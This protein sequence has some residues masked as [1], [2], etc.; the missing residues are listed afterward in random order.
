MQRELMDFLVELGARLARL[1]PGTTVAIED[2]HRT[3][4]SFA[5][6]FH[7]N[8]ER[9]AIT[10]FLDARCA[11]YF[12]VRRDDLARAGELAPLALFGCETAGCRCAFA[13]PRAC[14][15]HCDRD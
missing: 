9:L 8:A 6:A 10:H 1:E 11:L 7:R 4:R 3:E 2:V 14:C 15:G 5:T 13:T 12:S